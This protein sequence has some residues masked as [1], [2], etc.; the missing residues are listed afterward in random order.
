MRWVVLMA[1]AAGCGVEES[2]CGER[3]ETGYTAGEDWCLEEYE[4]ERLCCDGDDCTAQVVYFAPSLELEDDGRGTSDLPCGTEA[5]C[6]DWLVG[7]EAWCRWDALSASERI[8]NEPPPFP[9][10][11]GA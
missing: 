7:I 10:R 5:E 9:E 1:F 3:V 11:V 4:P 8:G 6:L 2:P